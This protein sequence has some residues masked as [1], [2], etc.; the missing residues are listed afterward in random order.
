[1][2]SNRVAAASL[3]GIYFDYTARGETAE[4]AN[5]THMVSALMALTNHAH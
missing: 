3:L 1:M 5:A 4:I 2:I